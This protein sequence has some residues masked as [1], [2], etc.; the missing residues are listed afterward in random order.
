MECWFTENRFSFLHGLN[1]DEPS[2]EPILP[3]FQYSNIPVRY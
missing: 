3:F 2:D 1:S